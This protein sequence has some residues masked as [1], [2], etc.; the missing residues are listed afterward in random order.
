[1]MDPSAEKFRKHYR[2]EIQMVSEF[3][4][5]ASFRRHFGNRKLKVVT[6]IAMFYDVDEPLTFM[7]EIASLLAD[8]GI[9]VFEQSYFPSMVEQTS[10]DTVCHEHQEY[11]ALKQIVWM[12][13]RAGLAVIDVELNNINGGSFSV[14]VALRKS[15]HATSANGVQKL[16]AN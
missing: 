1:G 4:S 11:Y 16:L 10:Y 9:W 2:P 5:G 14:I 15:A 8:D 6:S 7:Q 12:T 3:F 13:A